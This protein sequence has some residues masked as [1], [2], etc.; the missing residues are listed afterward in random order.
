[1]VPKGA[2]RQM[3]LAAMEAAE[4]DQAVI[5]SYE[6]KDI[7]PDTRRDPTVLG[8]TSV[9][10]YGEARQAHPDRFIWFIDSID[11]QDDNY[12]ARVERDLARGA[13]GIKMFPAYVETLPNDP[14]YRRLY[15]LCRE[16]RLPIIM[17][18]EHW[19]DP[20]WG[21]CMRNYPEFLGTFEPVAHAYPNVRVP[22]H[23]LGLLQLGRAK[24]S[25]R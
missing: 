3:L 21:A 19:N 8:D 13:Q 15:D 4:V 17:A 2:S 14:R 23:P 16:R 20:G 22:A 10:D 25:T 7:L 5:I 6:G 18:F 12:L 1:M 11:P 24:R 9:E